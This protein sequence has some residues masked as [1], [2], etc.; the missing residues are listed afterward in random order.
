M[1]ADTAEGRDKVVFIDENVIVRVGYA[2]VEDSRED[3]SEGRLIVDG[4]AVIGE[5]YV[6]VDGTSVIGAGEKS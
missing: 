4:G 6:R 2:Q 5:V 1:V 3:S